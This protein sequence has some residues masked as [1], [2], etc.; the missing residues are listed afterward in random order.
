MFSFLSCKSY[1]ELPTVEK[2]DL[3]KYVGQWYEIARLPNKF[4]KGLACVTA[5][6]NIDK[7]GKIAIINKGFLPKINKFKSAKGTAW[8]P[9]SRY[10]G[11]LKVTFFWP[12]SG[13]YY[14]IA[15]DDDYQNALVGDPSRDY[16]WILSRNKNIEID[17][18]TKFLV[19]A[20]SNG[21]EVN[22]LIKINQNCN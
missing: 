20:Q 15:L 2:V 4:E 9:N 6:Y 8:V 14:I 10:P 16:L 18:Y 5:N 22:N 13:D 11:R 7:A 19:I 21:F 3:K 12:F 17:T 1:K